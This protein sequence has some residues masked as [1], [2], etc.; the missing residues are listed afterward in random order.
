MLGY[1]WSAWQ[2]DHAAPSWKPWRMCS[3][4]GNLRMYSQLESGLCSLS[5]WSFS[6]GNFQNHLEKRDA[7]VTNLKH[8][9]SGTPISG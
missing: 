6:G 1:F 9:A 5:S 2:V 8:S 3:H 7:P 4:R